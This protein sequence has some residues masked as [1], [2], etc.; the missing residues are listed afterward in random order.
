MML[1]RQLAKIELFVF[2]S[3][4][5]AAA[6]SGVFLTLDITLEPSELLASPR[7]DAFAAGFIAAFAFG[8]IP[9]FFFGAPIYLILFRHGR[10]SW[11]SS[12]ALGMVLSSPLFLIGWQI[13][14][15]A[16]SCGAMAAAF[17]HAISRR[18]LSPNKSFKPNPLRGSA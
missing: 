17:T 10:A 14:V 3:M 16:I 12:I 11:V 13:G 8:S 4:L 5:L 2:L 1:F 9:A 18:W 15:L 6:M 7:A